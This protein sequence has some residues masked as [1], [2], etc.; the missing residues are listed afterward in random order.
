MIDFKIFHHSDDELW[1]YIGRYGYDSSVRSELGGIMSSDDSTWWVVTISDSEVAGFA[2]LKAKKR[3]LSHLYVLPQF[4]RRGIAGE[5]IARRIEL[6]RSI[7]LP[8]VKVAI[9]PSR[10]KHY[11]TNGFTELYTRGKWHWMRLD[12]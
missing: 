7:G 10:I 8:F 11:V 3:T 12:L 6:A 4:R 1:R 2:A 9:R 5:L